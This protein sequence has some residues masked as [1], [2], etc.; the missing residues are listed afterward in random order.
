MELLFYGLCLLLVVDILPSFFG[1]ILMFL[2]LGALAR[3]SQRFAA[4]RPWCAGVGVVSL[5]LRGEGTWAT[6]LYAL[7]AAATLFI[8]YRLIAAME[9]LLQRY[10]VEESFAATLQRRFAAVVVAEVIFQGATVL[11]F[12][13]LVVGLIGL[14]ALVI[15]ILFLMAFHRARLAYRDAAEKMGK[16]DA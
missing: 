1:L 7:E 2:G 5:F 16:N 13:T 14:A 10:G 9:E 15:D 4:L 3:E 6:L 8:L 12:N 11:G